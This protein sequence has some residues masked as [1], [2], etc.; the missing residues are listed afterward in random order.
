MRTNKSITLYHYDGESERFSRVYFPRASV[1][2]AVL[3]AVSE[4][5]LVMDSLVKIRIPIAGKAGLNSSTAG[6]NS[7][8]TASDSATDI[9]YNDGADSVEVDVG[10]Y[11]FIGKSEFSKPDR[12]CCHKVLGFSHNLR[13]ANPHVR[14]EAK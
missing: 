9:F 3:A 7:G 1:H 2:K 10:D 5:G 12:A 13:G 4:G 8:T 14:I 11:V 6:L